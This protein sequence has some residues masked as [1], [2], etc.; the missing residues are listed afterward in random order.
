PRE[1][2]RRT[3]GAPVGRRANRT[4]FLLDMLRACRDNQQVIRRKGAP[5]RKGGYEMASTFTDKQIPTYLS[6]L[7]IEY[8][9]M[10]RITK[11]ADNRD[12]RGRVVQIT[13]WRPATPWDLSRVKVRLV[14]SDGSLGDEYLVVASILVAC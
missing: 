7:G 6:S 11:I 2:F 8:G 9:R 13:G 4:Y 12:I 1:S 14:E 3:T 10:M 5:N